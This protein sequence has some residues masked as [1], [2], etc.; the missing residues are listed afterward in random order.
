MSVNLHRSA[1]NLIKRNFIIQQDNEP[2][3]TA[4]STKHFIAGEKLNV[5]GFQSPDL[6]P[7]ENAFHILRK[8]VK[9]KSP[10]NKITCST[11]Q[12]KYHR[13]KNATAC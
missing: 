6:G 10:N 7:I 5:L 13:K 11:N 3:P 2:K 8:R 1:Y 12:E 4:G 9:G